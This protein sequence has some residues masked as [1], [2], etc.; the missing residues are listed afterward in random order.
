MLKQRCKYTVK[1]C[2]L[3]IGGCAVYAVGIGLF[4]E[5]NGL[6]PAGVSGLA[7]IV[8]RCIYM[9]FGIEPWATGTVIVI[10]NLPILVMGVCKFGARFLLST[11]FATLLSSAFI[12]RI[13]DCISPPTDELLLASILGGAFMSFGMSMVFKGGA[14]TGGTDVV[15]RLLRTRYKHIKTGQIFWITDGIIVVLSVL[16][17]GNINILLYAFIT[18]AIQT[19]VLNTALYGSDSAVMVYIISEKEKE[20]SAM[21]LNRFGVGV[22]LL[23]GEGAYTGHGKNVILC[24]VKNRQLPLLKDTV[25]LND[26]RAFMIVTKANEIFGEGFKDHGTQEI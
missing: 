26:K 6:T 13:E 21:L 16:T 19:F 5:P 25:A 24:V 8:N 23:K 3:I 15:V 4:L 10:I 14:T 7:I 12:N 2:L 20:I 11:V 1:S 9:W 18:L 17:F 22:T